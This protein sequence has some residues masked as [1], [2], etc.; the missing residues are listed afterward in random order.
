MRLVSHFWAALGAEYLL[1]P[2]FRTLPSRD[3]FTTLAEIGQHEY[4]RERVEKL[5]FCMGELDRSG[6]R[7]SLYVLFF[8]IVNEHAHTEAHNVFYYKTHE[9]RLLILGYLY[10]C[11][12]RSLKSR[13]VFFMYRNPCL[14]M[15][16]SFL[17]RQCPSA[18]YHEDHGSFPATYYAYF[19]ISSFEKL[20]ETAHLS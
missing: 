16:R 5:L 18:T 3:D 1:L 8:H 2:T 19:I 6:A 4:F 20:L 14:T 15:S 11:L 9:I 7:M 17:L 13:S 12:A 10:H